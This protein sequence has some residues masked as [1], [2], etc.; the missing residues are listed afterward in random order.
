M[1]PDPPVG[2]PD[3]GGVGRSALIDVQVTVPDPL[4]FGS[5]SGDPSIGARAGWQWLD[6]AEGVPSALAAA[7]D[8]IDAVL[9]DRGLRRTSAEATVESLLRGAIAS[10]EL[11]GSGSTGEAIRAGAGDSVA[12]GAVRVSVQLLAVAPVWRANP[13]QAL[14][15]LH[16]LAG[17]GLVAEDELGRPA[18]PEEAQRLQW[19][20][21][22]LADSDSAPALGVAAVVHAEVAGGLFADASM[23][24]GDQLPVNG[25]VARAAERLVLASR[26]VDPTS[27]TVP[28]A[29]HLN[30]GAA[31]YRN[32]LTGFREGG[33]G[34]VVAWLMHCSAAY[35][36]GAEASPVGQ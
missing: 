11:A 23:S 5:M 34:G 29:G 1:P 31:T 7:R 27:V 28:E 12:L 2:G 13:V 33:E 15:R 3:S 35:A 4:A 6:Q 10:A 30:L 20:G 25:L 14:A 17:T 36:G 21:R 24:T 26:G 18:G 9:R 22:M 16:V 19:L 8:G 32:R